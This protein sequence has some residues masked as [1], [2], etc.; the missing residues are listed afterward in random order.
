MNKLLVHQEL[1]GFLGRRIPALGET[2]QIA[3]ALGA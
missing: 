2:A 3:E 1:P